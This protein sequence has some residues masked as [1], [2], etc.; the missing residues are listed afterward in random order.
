MP[1]GIKKTLCSFF[2]TE[3]YACMC[4]AYYGTYGCLLDGIARL[5]E[6][7]L[8]LAAVSIFV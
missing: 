5:T 7:T 3:F 1:L 8:Y 4:R 2:V 6:L